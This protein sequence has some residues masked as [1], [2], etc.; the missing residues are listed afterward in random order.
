MAKAK[1]KP[2]VAEL[3]DA[4]ADVTRLALAARTVL[5]T[6]RGWAGTWG[7]IREQS[8]VADPLDAIDMARMLLRAGGRAIDG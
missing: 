3:L 6:D 5:L 1:R 4:L 2:T 7:K 8:G